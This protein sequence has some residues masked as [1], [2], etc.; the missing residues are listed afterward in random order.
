MR[1]YFNKSSREISSRSALRRTLVDVH[2]STS[3]ILISLSIRNSVQVRVDA[4]EIDPMFHLL[5]VA[6]AEK[7]VF[8]T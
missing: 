8:R 1:P 4:C 7:H 6:L 3:W 5:V 2:F